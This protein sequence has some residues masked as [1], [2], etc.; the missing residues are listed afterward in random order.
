MQKIQTPTR[1]KRIVLEH[2]SGLMNGLHSILGLESEA[3]SP[4]QEFVPDVDMKDHHAPCSLVAVKR[5]YV[6]YRELM[7]PE[8]TKA[9]D[10]SQ[11]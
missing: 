4:L 9:F 3:P 10:R 2:T 8:Q 11:R 6:L 1:D 5:S 7:L